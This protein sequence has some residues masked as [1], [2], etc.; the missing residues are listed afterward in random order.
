MFSKIK[1]LVDRYS[2]HFF[3]FMILV[4]F[5]NCLYPFDHSLWGLHIE[6]LIMTKIFPIMGVACGLVAIVFRKLNLF[7]LSLILYFALWIKLFLAFS[8]FPYFLGI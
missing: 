2:W 3:A 4:F 8:L 7:I 1:C 5:L 6:W